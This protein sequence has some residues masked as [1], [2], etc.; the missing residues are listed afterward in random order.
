MTWV[1][2]VAVGIVAVAALGGASQGLAWSGL[3]LAG[4]VGGAFLGGK[5]VAPF[6]LTREAHSLYAP[7]I[8]LGCAIGL[9]VV[10]ETVG[11]TA[12]AALGRRLRA[13]PLG[14]LDVIGGVLFG[15]VSGLAIVWVLAIVGLNLP[16]RPQLRRELQRSVVIRELSSIAPPRRFLNLL[17]RIDPLPTIVGP[18]LPS[19]P[20]DPQVL[21]RPGVRAA[22][23]GVV[24]I[25]GTACGLGVAGSGWIAGPGVVVT[26]AHVVAGEDDT[27]VRPPSGGSFPAQAIAFDPHNDIAVLRVPGLRGRALRLAEPRSGAGMA[28]LGYPENGPFDAEPGRV[29]TTRS[30]FTQDAYG[31]PTFRMVTSFSGKVRPGNSGGPVVDAT[32]AVQATVFAAP[33]RGGGGFGVPSSIVR[34]DLAGARGRVSTGPCAR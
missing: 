15:A 2:W 25:V 8:A 12:G 13:S 11:S 29:G 6:V 34:R 24:R 7:L 14:P 26:A 31:R 30:V 22:A 21:G 4:L 33:L 5:Y 9:A 16:G 19:E 18:A 20:P 3:S 28:I 17:A 23:P 1:D 10:F 32:G 27:R